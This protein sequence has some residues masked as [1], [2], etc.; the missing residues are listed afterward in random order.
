MCC[1][2]VCVLANG[3]PCPLP[4][5]L[6]DLQAKVG[7]LSEDGLYIYTECPGA[8][9]PTAE[10]RRGCARCQS[11]PSGPKVTDAS[12]FQGLSSDVSWQLIYQAQLASPWEL[13]AQDDRE[14]GK[15]WTHSNQVA[16]WLCQYFVD[17]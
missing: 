15:G 6:P 8:E 2:P 3:K 9:D 11:P 4:L 16:C 13:P 10:F 5:F 12:V 17:F 14:E 1:F 7:H